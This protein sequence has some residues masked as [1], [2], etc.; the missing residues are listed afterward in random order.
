MDLAVGLGGSSVGIHS[1]LL[2]GTCSER[3]AF[4]LLWVSFRSISMMVQQ[5]RKTWEGCLCMIVE[6]PFRKRIASRS[7]VG[8]HRNALM[9][10]H[11][12]MRTH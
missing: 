9:A 2:A 12:G 4:R 1:F 5:S 11:D 8:R 10:I 7:T 3:I 6:L